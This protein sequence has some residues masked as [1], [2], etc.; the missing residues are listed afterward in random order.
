MF[1]TFL[2]TVVYT[3]SQQFDASAFKHQGYYVFGLSVQ[4]SILASVHTS[5]CNLSVCPSIWPTIT[6]MN[7]WL[8]VLSICPSQE[9]SGE[10]VGG[11]PWNFACWCIL[12]SFTVIL[13]LVIF[14]WYSP[15]WVD[16]VELAKFVSCKNSYEY[17]RGMACI[18]T[19]IWT[20]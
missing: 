14:C 10:R 7:N 3:I 6:Q 20:N 12:T 9:F 18:L 15:F 1:L 8:L 16:L 4:L 2:L 5:F 17:V 11:I 19:T 13:N